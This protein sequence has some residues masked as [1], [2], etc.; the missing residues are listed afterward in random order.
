[1]GVVRESLPII[2]LP[3]PFRQCFSPYDVGAVSPLMIEVYGDSGCGKS[4]LCAQIARGYRDRG[5]EVVY[6]L[7]EKGR[8]HTVLMA[9]KVLGSGRCVVVP[10]GL[11]FEHA[12]EVLGTKNRLLWVIDSLTSVGMGGGYACLWNTY[13]NLAAL[14]C[15]HRGRESAL[16][17]APTI[18]CIISQIREGATVP[19][20]NIKSSRPAHSSSVNHYLHAIFRLRQVH[21]QPGIITIIPYHHA[22]LF[23]N[24]APGGDSL[25]IA[26]YDGKFT[27]RETEYRL[28]QP[29]SPPE[30]E[31]IIP[32][33]GIPVYDFQPG[34]RRKSSSSR[35]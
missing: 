29:I 28:E 31:V 30:P 14:V 9:S 6:S 20:T 34:S 2:R 16:R 19:G 23:C 32:Q 33:E 8:D 10:P 27:A 1:M 17:D 26:A 22:L 15:E 13:N 35:K 11:F 3:E 18:V 21:R 7:T 24:P 25:E 4:L 12:K 5:W